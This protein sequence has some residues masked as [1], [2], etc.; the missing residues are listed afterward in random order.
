[1]KDNNQ[2]INKLYDEINNTK[3]NDKIDIPKIKKNKKKNIPIIEDN[4]SEEEEYNE[5]Q[6]KLT[7]FG[8]WLGIKRVNK[9]NGIHEPEM[10]LIN[11]MYDIINN[12]F[13]QNEVLNKMKNINFTTDAQHSIMNWLEK[14]N[15]KGSAELMDFI[16]L[17][18]SQ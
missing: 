18:V 9:E 5:H 14:K 13:K 1:M 12:H 10:K 2:K 4:K 8:D 11:K 17:V 7:F 16:I 6:N 3:I 15:N